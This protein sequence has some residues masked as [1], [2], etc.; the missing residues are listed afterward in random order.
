MR[1]AKRDVPSVMNVLSLAEKA[2]MSPEARDVLHDA[3]IE[4][5]GDRYLW[6]VHEAVRQGRLARSAK[7]RRVVKELG[8]PR[9]PP[10]VYLVVLEAGR[11]RQHEALSKPRGTKTPWGP[12]RG[13]YAGDPFYLMTLDQKRASA[14]GAP[15]FIGRADRI[16]TFTYPRSRLTTSRFLTAENLAVPP[17]RQRHQIED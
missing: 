4:R 11:V 5:Y 9:R 17:G 7:T 15:F 16:I 8:H 10:P 6:Y 14:R 13:A 12:A 2:R 1:R 3:L